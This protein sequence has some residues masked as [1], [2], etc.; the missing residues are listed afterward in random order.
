MALAPAQQDAA[1]KVQEMVLLLAADWLNNDR[2]H[3]QDIRALL[4]AIAADLDP[5]VNVDVPY[6][7]QQDAATLTCTMGNWDG[8][9]SSYAYAWHTD[10]VANGA[11]GETYAVQPG[12][13]DHGLACVVTAT[14]ALGST[15]APMSNT[16]LVV[17]V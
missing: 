9:P 12:D 16:V 14:N 13:V 17:D 1:A 5:P 8:Q 4:A 7:W 2:T 11:S 3:A 15:A 6:A 10:G